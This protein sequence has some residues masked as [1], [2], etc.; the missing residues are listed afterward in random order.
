M[1]AAACT[2]GSRPVDR[3]GQRSV[4]CLPGRACASLSCS[5]EPWTKRRAVLKDE[6]ASDT[7]PCWVVDGGLD[8]RVDRAS[9][10]LLS[11]AYC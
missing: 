11:T 8:T 7:N 9:V 10:S 5:A 6:R 4:S 2:C 1:C 3:A